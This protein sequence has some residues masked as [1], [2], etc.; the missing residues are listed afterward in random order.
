MAANVGSQLQATTETGDWTSPPTSYTYQWQEATTSGGSYSNIASAT[1]SDYIVVTG[2]IGKYIRCQITATNAAGS[3]S[4]TN[5]G[6]VGPV[7]GVPLI[8]GNTIP[9]VI[10]GVAQVGQTLSCS[11]GSWTN[12]PTSYAYQWQDSP[13]GSAWSNIVVA[14]SNTYLIPLGELARYIRCEV[15]AS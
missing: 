11:T 6:I 10:S 9:P 8:P 2:D 15:T 14:T 3:S 1:R 4:A 5:T 13:D 12:S 7:T